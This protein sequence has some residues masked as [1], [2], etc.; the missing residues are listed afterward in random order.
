MMEEDAGKG[1]AGRWSPWGPPGKRGEGQ[2]GSAGQ[3]G[4]W[5]VGIPAARVKHPEG[6]GPGG[7]RNPGSANETSGCLS[8]SVCEMIICLSLQGK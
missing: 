8:L 6:L 5:Q 7:N 4:S 1:W 2:R 3:R